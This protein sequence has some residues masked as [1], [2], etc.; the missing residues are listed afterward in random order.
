MPDPIRGSKAWKIL[1]LMAGIHDCGLAAYHFF[2]PVHWQWDRGLEGVPP[3]LVWA[4]Y[5]LNFS[6]SLLVLLIGMLV[7]YAALLGPSAGAF[8][9]RTI[10]T[11]GLFWAIHGA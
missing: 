2:L 6:W 9:R 8:M 4:L 7:I 10:F 11:V 5:A 3:S 1:L